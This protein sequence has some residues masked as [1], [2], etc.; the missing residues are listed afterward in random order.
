VRA[1]AGNAGGTG[2]YPL[3]GCFGVPA[4]PVFPA[5]IRVTRFTLGRLQRGSMGKILDIGIK[6]AFNAIDL[7]M[8]R[9]PVCRFVDKKRFARIGFGYKTSIGMA[10]ET[11]LGTLDLTGKNA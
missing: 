3:C 6:M 1:V 5:F 2:Q 11:Y 7:C 9:M 8:R 4:Y 10:F